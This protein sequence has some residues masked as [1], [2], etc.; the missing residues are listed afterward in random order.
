MTPEGLFRKTYRIAS[1]RLK[2]WDYSSPGH[3]SVTICTQDKQCFFGD[4]V[5][6]EEEPGAAIQFSPAGQ[7]I[8]KF[9]KMIPRWYPNVSLD[10]WQIMPN[11]F[12]G[13]LF[14]A[15]Q[16][17]GVTLGLIINQFKA[18]CTK[19]IRNMGLKDFA[20]QPRFHDHI[21]RN[22]KDLER[23]Q[24]YIRENPAAWLYGE[25]ED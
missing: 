16:K 6:I 21:V 10:D 3:Y 23:V 19:D 14:I 1:A 18:E 20:W 7:T 9:W 13:I 15:E 2:E 22:A 11:H 5:E 24:R 8:E 25:D 4:I 17:E 12:H